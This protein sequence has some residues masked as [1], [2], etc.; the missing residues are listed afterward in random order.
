MAG[1]I[2]ESGREEEGDVGRGVVRGSG[3]FVGHG[4]VISRSHP[5]I[6]LACG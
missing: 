4:W 6:L 5:S 2:R 3:C 1:V